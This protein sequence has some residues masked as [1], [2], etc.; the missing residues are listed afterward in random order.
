MIDDA[1][2]RTFLFMMLGEPITALPP[3]ADDRPTLPI[4]EPILTVVTATRN[5]TMAAPATEAHTVD[6]E[7]V[8]VI[9]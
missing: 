7:E 2:F 4:A 1:W 5:V 3:G 8:F 9:M 6:P